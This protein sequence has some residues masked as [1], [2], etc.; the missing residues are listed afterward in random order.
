MSDFEKV[1][2]VEKVR[3]IVTGNAREDTGLWAMDLHY[4][5]PCTYGAG[6]RGS[7]L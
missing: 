6:S 1:E 4:Y 7:L 2:K 5:D 3:K